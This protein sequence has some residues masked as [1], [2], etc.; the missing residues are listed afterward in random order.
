MDDESTAGARDDRTADPDDR[1]GPRIED[2]D[3]ENWD[4]PRVERAASD[5]AQAVV[6]GFPDMDEIIEPGDIDL[7]NAVFVVL[8]VLGTIALFVYVL[9]ILP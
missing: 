6:T 7:E 8:G 9:S 5:D 3:D 4:P 1:A 2:D